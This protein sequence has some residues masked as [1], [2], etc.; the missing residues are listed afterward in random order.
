MTQCHPFTEDVQV[1]RPSAGKRIDALD[2]SS[3]GQHALTHET[4][5][6]TG[7]TASPKWQTS[8][9]PHLYIESCLIIARLL[10]RL[11]AWALAQGGYVDTMRALGGG[12]GPE[13]VTAALAEALAQPWRPNA[14]KICAPWPPW[15][16]CPVRC[17]G[18]HR[19]RAAPWAGAQRRRLPQRGPRGPG[20]AGALPR[21]GCREHHRLHRGL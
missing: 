15:T 7:F 19:G 1:M 20:P 21:H 11:S 18:A 16:W 12:D 2:R 4:P 17:R 14:T 13:A 9:Y 10:R 6:S 8:L 5:G 3:G